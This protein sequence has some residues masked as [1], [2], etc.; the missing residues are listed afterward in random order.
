MFW[1]ELVIML[2]LIFWGVRKEEFSL[3]LPVRS[4]RLSLHLS[5]SH[6]CRI[7]AHGFANYSGR[8]YCGWRD[9]GCGW[10]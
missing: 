6:P 5:L 9:A 8:G 1:I 10:Y 2:L 4:A 3:R 7:P